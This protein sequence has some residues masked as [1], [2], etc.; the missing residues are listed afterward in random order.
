MESYVDYSEDTF[1]TKTEKAQSAEKT[2]L[3]DFLIWQSSVTAADLNLVERRKQ[4]VDW[5]R[6]RVCVWIASTDQW[7]VYIHLIMEINV[8][9]ICTTTVIFF[10]LCAHAC[11]FKNHRRCCSWRGSLSNWIVSRKR[12]C[13][14]CRRRC[15][16]RI[17]TTVVAFHYC[18]ASLML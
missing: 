3:L 5:L 11:V 6:A 14:C 12:C 9:I 16:T 15:R 1:I 10:N 7:T 8:S 2:L 18:L 4:C 17:S 13:H